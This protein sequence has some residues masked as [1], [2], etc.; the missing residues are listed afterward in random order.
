MQAISHL[1][2]AETWQIQCSLIKEK[3]LRL[4]KRLNSESKV[5][6]VEYL[7]GTGGH[8]KYKKS[9]LPAYAITFEHTSKTTIYVPS[10]LGANQK[11]KNYKWR[12]LDFL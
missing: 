2:N 6:S 4:Q 8:H 5:K 7:T 9:L 10:E 11:F 1:A 3:P 12:I